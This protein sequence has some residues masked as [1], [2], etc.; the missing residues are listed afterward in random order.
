MTEKINK[1]KGLISGQVDM[2]TFGLVELE[3]RDIEKE[4]TELLKHDVSSILPFVEWL[5]CR[6][7][8]FHDKFIKLSGNGKFED[9]YTTTQP[10][11][12]WDDVVRDF[13]NN[14]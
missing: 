10:F 13:K 6:Y 14:S 9:P 8:L 4:N 11:V 1:I 12:T 5:S 3:L 2:G 7:Q